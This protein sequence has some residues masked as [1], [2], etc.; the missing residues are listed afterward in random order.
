MTPIDSTFP[1]TEAQRQVHA[2]QRLAGFGRLRFVPALEAEFLAELDQDHARR[3]AWL[4]V[5]VLLIWALLAVSDHWRIDASQLS[6]AQRGVWHELL[7]SRALIGSF[8]IVSTSLAWRDRLGPARRHWVVA[9]ALLI[10]TCGGWGAT[11][12]LRLPGYQLMEILVLLTAGL[13]LPI[14]LTL[15]QTLPLVGACLLAVS[16]VGLLRLD[17]DALARYAYTV[18]LM[19]G[20]ALVCAYGAYFREY[21]QREQFLMRAELSWQASHDALTGLSNR[22]LFDERLRLLLRQS[23]REQQGLVLML[24]D[25]DH[26]KGFNDRYGHPAGDQALCDLAN[27]LQAQASRPLDLAA[28]LGGEEMALLLYGARRADAERLAST[29]LERLR[30][31]H[32]AHAGSASGRLSLSVGL[33]EASP[34]DTARS[35]YQRADRLLYLAKQRGRDQVVAG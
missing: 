12:Y 7:V 10:C 16:A 35:L 26:F 5:L 21:A 32:I 9:G 6:R 20:T 8:L 27:L 13:F 17:G 4:S 15:R 34:D 22:R 3:L 24:L 25:V 11:C 30:G 2:Q 31:L 19:A 33:S 14:G 28:R 29:L 1:H 18:M 23:R